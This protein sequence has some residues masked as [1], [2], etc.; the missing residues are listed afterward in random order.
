MDHLPGEGIVGTDDVL[1]HGVAYD[2]FLLLPMVK[3]IPE[4]PGKVKQ[5]LP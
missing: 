5:D 1:T 3:V 4:A 2:R